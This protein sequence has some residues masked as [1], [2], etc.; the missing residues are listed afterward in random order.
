MRLIAIAFA[1]VIAIES[2]VAQQPPPVKLLVMM[3]NSWDNPGEAY[4]PQELA[5]AL[6]PG[7]QFAQ[8]FL[9]ASSG[10]RTF[11]VTVRPYVTI[12]AT[13]PPIDYNSCDPS[14][15]PV[16]RM[17]TFALNAATQAGI[18][19]AD[20][21]WMVV[22]P[23][24][25]C[26]G[27]AGFSTASQSIIL[28]RWSMSLW[29][30]EMWHLHQLQQFHPFVEICQDNSCRDSDWSVEAER[31]NIMSDWSQ[32]E[33]PGN[34]ERMNLAIARTWPFSPPLSGF[35]WI[36][37]ARVPVV[38][39]GQFTL[40][41]VD[42]PS[43]Q[44]G[45]RV[46]GPTS[47]DSFGEQIGVEVRR[48]GVVIR[49]ALKSITGQYVQPTLL[50]MDRTTPGNQPILPVGQTYLWKGIPVTVVS[51]TG[52]SAVVRI[53]AGTVPALPLGV[54]NLRAEP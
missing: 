52:T 23:F 46:L 53:G 50:D 32:W 15:A 31:Y 37:P 22:T 41:P 51:V 21:V 49:R 4:T 29:A 26:Y 17:S 2:A 38:T 40:L 27:V 20:Y 25:G 43:G 7:S 19:T 1:L 39:S 10:K 5:S 47:T 14:R 35:A 42:S 28:G 30:H 3:V 34:L 18:R 6:G 11:D 13:E 9:G 36:D 54:S 8:F 48:D 12:P 44:I 24:F 33:Y 45:V 16:F